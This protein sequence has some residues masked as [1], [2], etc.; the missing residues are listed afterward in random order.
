MRS[1]A[2]HKRTGMMKFFSIKSRKAAAAA[3]IAAVF[4]I[5]VPVFASTG[6]G[7]EIYH[8]LSLIHI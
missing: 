3:V 2:H 4:A 5:T 7:T 1:M 6:A 8:K